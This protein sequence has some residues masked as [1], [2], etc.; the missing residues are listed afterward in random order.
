MSVQRVDRP[1]RCIRGHGRRT[2]K[3]PA[4]TRFN[5]PSL[6]NDRTLLARRPRSPAQDEGG[7]CSSPGMAS[8]SPFK[9]L[10]SQHGFISCSHTLPISAA[11]QSTGRELP[12]L[13][14]CGVSI[15]PPG[16]GGSALASSTRS[17]NRA[18]TII[19]LTTPSRP[20][21]PINPTSHTSGTRD[22]DY[23]LPG[24]P[25]THPSI[26]GSNRAE[27][28]KRMLLSN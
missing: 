7:S 27:R 12:P 9:T 6:G 25:A 22:V 28:S 16:S 2:A 21:S 24:T 20:A 10:T 14:S 23:A 17:L 8:V 15:P 5:R 13:P 4:R 19:T 11:Q 3:S 18:G 26:F 1:G